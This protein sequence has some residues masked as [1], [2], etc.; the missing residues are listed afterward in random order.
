MQINY[1]ERLMVCFSLW[2]KMEYIILDFKDIYYIIKAI[3]KC[4][5]FNKARPEQGKRKEEFN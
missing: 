5:A 4:E 3:I 2:R 1:F